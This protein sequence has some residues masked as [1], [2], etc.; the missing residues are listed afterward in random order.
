MRKPDQ[1]SNRRIGL[2][3]VLGVVAAVLLGVQSLNF[4][5]TIIGNFSATFM[6]FGY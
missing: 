6:I 4:I 5:V 2:V 3:D 1:V